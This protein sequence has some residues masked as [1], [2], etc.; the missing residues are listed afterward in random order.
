MGQLLGDC[1]KISKSADITMKTGVELCLPTSATRGVAS[2]YTVDAFAVKSADGKYTSSGKTVTRVGTKLCAL[3]T[4]TDTYFCPAKLATTHA[5]ATSDIGSNVCA[6]V[7][8]AKAIQLATENSLAQPSGTDDNVDLDALKADADEK[9]ADADAKKIIADEKTA[10]AEQKKTA[11][12][13]VLSGDALKKA[14]LLAD[15]AIAGVKVSKIA[16]PLTATSPA[17]ACETAFAKMSVEATNGMC[18]AETSSRR[19]NLQQTAYD[20]TVIVS[21]AVVDVSA[22]T[23]SLTTN[24][25]TAT[26]MSVDPVDEIALI[27]G[28]DLTKIDT[29]N[30]AAEEAAAASASYVLAEALAKE[31]EQKHTDASYNASDNGSLTEVENYVEDAVS[32]ASSISS[33]FFTAFTAALVALLA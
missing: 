5:T 2:E 9:R 15:A 7:D 6:F 23:A 28:I 24:G 20:V 10:V 12:L 19:R 11:L 26:M 32:A 17:E 21:P 22:V 3:V 33:G 31:A 4:E 25:I 16:M 14:T 18:E 1:T 8:D 13:S 27:D 30:T 29:F